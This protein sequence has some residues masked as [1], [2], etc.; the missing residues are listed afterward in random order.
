MT[1]DTLGSLRLRAERAEARAEK[2]EARVTELEG[3]NAT[4][5]FN[6]AA[7]PKHR[8]AEDPH[9]WDAKQ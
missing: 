2:A 3:K 4:L 6:A 5:R 7:T 8:Q 9:P 1:T